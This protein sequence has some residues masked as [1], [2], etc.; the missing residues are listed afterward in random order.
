MVI[1]TSAFFADIVVQGT[2]FIPGLQS[3]LALFRKTKNK[4]SKSNT[5]TKSTKVK[6]KSK[7]D[8]PF[9]HYNLF[10]I[11]EREL[12]LQSKGVITE[13]F[14][15]AKESLAPGSSSSRLS[16]GDKNYYGYI[17]IELPPMPSRYHSLVLP[18]DW[19]VHGKRRDKN[20]RKHRKSHGAASFVDIAKTIGSNW[21]SLSPQDDVVVYVKTIAK[22]TMN[23]RNELKLLAEDDADQHNGVATLCQPVPCATIV[24]QSNVYC[25]VMASNQV[26][27]SAKRTSVNLQ[28]LGTRN[29]EV[30]MT[31]ADII[32]L[33]KKTDV[34]NPDFD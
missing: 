11:L 27:V 29:G 17:G 24:D 1:R 21:K 33:W 14:S 12:L 2:G 5:Q 10:F 8:R 9:N 7:M 23:R 31:D 18:Y 25:D 19:F 22:K 13:L 15:A 3:P 32:E 26:S 28:E 30:D 6:T 20:P 4:M 16:F 34:D